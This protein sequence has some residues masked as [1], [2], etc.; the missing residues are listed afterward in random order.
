M[1]ILLF[2][3][4][5]DSNAIFAWLAGGNIIFDWLVGGACGRKDVGDGEEEEA[6][7]PRPDNN[8]LYYR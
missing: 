8:T 6:F 4:L 2:D 7:I 3:W 1:V 5:A